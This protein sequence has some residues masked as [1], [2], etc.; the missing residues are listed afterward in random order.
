M[1][2]GLLVAVLG[3]LH[4]GD[5]TLLSGVH[6]PGTHCLA[7]VAPGLGRATAGPPA[8]STAR[9]T[10]GST[11]GSPDEHEVELDRLRAAGWEVAVAEV[12]ERLDATWGRLGL[13]R[14]LVRGTRRGTM[15]G[16]RR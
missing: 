10:A 15:G 11:A 8:G 6:Q 2:G 5:S 14:Q 1:S 4:A 12:G 9:L 7:L 13:H 16:A 3:R